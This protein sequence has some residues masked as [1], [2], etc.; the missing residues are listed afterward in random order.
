MPIMSSRL[1]YAA[2]TWTNRA[3]KYVICRNAIIRTQRMA[4]LRVIWANRTVSANVALFLAGN[5]LGD[6]L[7]LERKSLRSKM[8]DPERTESVTDDW[9]VEWDII[10]LAWNTDGVALTIS[11]EPEESIRILSDKW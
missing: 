11:P 1:L 6:L 5:H 10:L 3:T 7:V 9:R 2:P 8:N 4:A